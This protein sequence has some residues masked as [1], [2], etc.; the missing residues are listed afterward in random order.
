MKDCII[1]E[2]M[3]LAQGQSGKL[4]IYLNNSKKYIDMDQLQNCDFEDGAKFV[5]YTIDE[6]P[7]IKK[8]IK[9]HEPVHNLR[10]N[11]PFVN[12][13]NYALSPSPLKIE[14]ITLQLPKDE[15]NKKRDLDNI[16][17]NIND[18]FI[19]GAA[20]VALILSV[21]NQVRQKKKDADNA[22]CC[23]NNKIEVNNIKVEMEKIKG[24]INSKHESSNKAIY[25]EMLEHYKELKE[26][27]DDLNNMKD[28]M[29][30]VIEKSKYIKKEEKNDK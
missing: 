6:K 10:N 24:E 5:F 15:E 14:N 21:I 7:P 25:A 11:I 4:Y 26:T 28:I 27:K 13:N 8:D 9:N 3:L 19:G 30:K 2:P 20:S 12:H 29:E 22:L 18:F 1:N 17:N 16:S 23:N